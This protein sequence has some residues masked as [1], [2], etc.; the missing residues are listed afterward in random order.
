MLQCE[1]INFFLLIW[2]KLRQLVEQCI[3]SRP[4]QRPNASEVLVNAQQAMTKCLNGKTT[5][6]SQKRR[7]LQPNQTSNTLRF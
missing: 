3:N 7:A 4:D 1:S 6:P 2:I 5:A